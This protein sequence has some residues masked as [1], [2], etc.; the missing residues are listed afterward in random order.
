MGE[1]SQYQAL[2]FL[3]HALP[4]ADASLVPALLADEPLFTTAEAT[5]AAS[6]QRAIPYLLTN[7]IRRVAQDP[8]IVAT[9]QSLLG[10][11]NWV[12]WGPNIRRATPNQA[13][14]WHVDLE[15]LLWPTLTIA[16]GLSGCTPQSATWVIPGTHLLQQPPPPTPTQVLAHGAPQQITGFADGHFYAFDARLWHRGDPESSRNRVVLFLHYHR[17]S[18]P[19]IPLMLDYHHQQWAAQPAPYFSALPA[20]SISSRIAP[21]PLWYRLERWQLAWRHKFRRGGA[22]A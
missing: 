20:T 22:P 21:L 17:A 18:D 7:A 5:I 1:T 12:M 4:L 2:G 16:V 19:R 8:A 3:P 14:N 13:Q 6:G 10:A 15:S 9:V 11:T